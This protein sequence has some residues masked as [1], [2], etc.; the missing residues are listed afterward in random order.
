V[1][2]RDVELTLVT[3]VFDAAKPD[4]LAAVLAKYVV[5]SRQQ[6]GC[7]NIDLCE[8]LTRPGRFVVVE[9]WETPAEQQAHFNSPD[10][11][12]MATS[13]EGLLQRPPD[14]DLLQALS[15]HDLR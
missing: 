9:K 13:C 7:R 12:E 11:I 10:M 8:S 3:M 6:K 2:D 15:A 1:A 5:L 4:E 14:I